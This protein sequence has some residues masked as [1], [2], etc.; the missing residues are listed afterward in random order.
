MGI[1]P[2]GDRV[3]IELKKEEETKVG[4]LYIPDTAREKPQQAV[5]VAVGEGEEGKALSV[6][7]DDTV[8]YAKYVGTEVSYEGKDYLILQESDILAV[9]S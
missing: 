5:V 1:K 3:L 7:K 4:S 8:L 6:K 2:I 9:I